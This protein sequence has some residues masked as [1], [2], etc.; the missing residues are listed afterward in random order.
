M[1]VPSAIFSM[2]NTAFL[3]VMFTGVSLLFKL[4]ITIPSLV[5]TSAVNVTFFPGSVS[6][7]P[8]SLI[9]VGTCLIVTVDVAF[10]ALYVLSPSNFAVALYV[11]AFMSLRLMFIWPLESVVACVVLS[12]SVIVTVFP[13]NALLFCVNVAVNVAV[14]P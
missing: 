10:D 6:S 13:L 7:A 14:S 12:F 1:Y 11:F 4:K 3:F 5:L 8:V 9:V 2:F